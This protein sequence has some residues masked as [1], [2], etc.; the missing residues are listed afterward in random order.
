MKKTIIIISIIT[1][2]LCL[3]KQETIEIPK[4]SIR[5]RVIANSNK[6][7]DQKIKKQVLNKL[8][9]KLQEIEKN[10]SLN[11]A[12]VS[13]IKELPT[14]D[15]IVKENINNNSYTINYGNN[16]FPEK[17]YN[18]K[19]Y[20]KGEYESLV[21]TIGEGK[22]KN[23]WCVLFPPLCFNKENNNKPQKSYIKNFIKKY[24]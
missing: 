20:Q 21:I 19:I 24:F 10:N 2:I 17:A 4:E 22:G 14:I 16:F 5:F 7:A 12:R 3:N 15:E 18:G 13:I 1:T 6:I 9:N 8:T 23:F 11:N